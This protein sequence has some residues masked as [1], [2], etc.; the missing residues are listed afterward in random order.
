MFWKWIFHN[1]KT[2][3]L[4]ILLKASDVIE[5]RTEFL[6]EACRCSVSAALRPHSG[7]IHYGFFKSCFCLDISLE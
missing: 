4:P 2:K 3:K 6:L 1:Y 5:N 7:L